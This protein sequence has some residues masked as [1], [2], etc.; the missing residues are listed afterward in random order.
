MTIPSLQ[1]VKKIVERE[2]LFIFLFACILFFTALTAV[3]SEA[4]RALEPEKRTTISAHQKTDLGETD[5]ALI[6]ARIRKLLDE[7]KDLL[8]I[9]NITAAL[10]V[11]I[12]VCG[13]LIDVFLLVS[14][15]RIALRSSEAHQAAGW[16]ILD[17]ARSLIVI[18]FLSYVVVYAEVIVERIFPAVKHE[19]FRMMLSTTV[20][21]LACVIVILHFALRRNKEPLSSLG[22]SLKNGLRNAVVGVLGYIGAMPVLVIVAVAVFIV[23]RL[24]HYTPERQLI[25][26]LFAR[27]KNSVFLFYASVFT[28]VIGPFV[29]ELFFR[30]FMYNAARKTFGVAWA[31][32]LTSAI[33]AGLHADIVGFLPIMALGMLLAYLYERTGTLVASITVHFTHNLA[34]IYLVFLARQLQI[35]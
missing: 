22:L 35:L 1:E 14:R 12:I 34:M 16:T 32:V 19:H 27:E 6:E 30:G 25:V 21:D 24:A 26:D 29:E 18:S 20:I 3:S 7:R 11:L 13:L 10:I 33:F 28:A 4:G 5:D 15:R 23:V 2:S 17:V 8:L 31:M 9:V